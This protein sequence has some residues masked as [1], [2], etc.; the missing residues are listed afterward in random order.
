MRSVHNIVI[1]R[2]WLRLRLELGNNAV[3]AFRKGE[4]DHAYRPNDPKHQ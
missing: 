2:T 3:D 4:E 1:E